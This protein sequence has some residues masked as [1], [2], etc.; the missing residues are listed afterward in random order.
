MTYNENSPLHAAVRMTS[1]AQRAIKRRL[2]SKRRVS[3]GQVLVA[4]LIF[5]AQA[6]EVPQ[7]RTSSAD[8]Q[9]NNNTCHARQNY[10]EPSSNSFDE[11]PPAE[12]DGH[13]LPIRN[14]KDQ[15]CKYNYADKK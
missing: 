7:Q 13:Q 15:G 1:E 8:N 11:R 2:F 9:E 6:S 3:L 14:D 12:A 10:E 5:A 4:V